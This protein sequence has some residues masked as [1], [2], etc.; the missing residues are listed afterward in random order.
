MMTLSAFMIFFN[1]SFFKQGEFCAIVLLLILLASCQV[2][3]ILSNDS[4]SYVLFIDI[5]LLSYVSV[6]VMKLSS[7]LKK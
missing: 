5:V 3:M 4:I 6:Q 1:S 7:F 2:I